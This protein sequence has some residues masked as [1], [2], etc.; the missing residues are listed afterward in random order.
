MKKLF[1]LLMIAAVAA[2]PLWSRSFLPGTRSVWS[3]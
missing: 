3:V 2:M 1:A